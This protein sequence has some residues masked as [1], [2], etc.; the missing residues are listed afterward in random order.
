MCFSWL[1]C[2]TGHFVDLYWRTT[3]AQEERNGGKR[4]GGKKCEWRVGKERRGG[5]LSY[6][7]E[8][9]PI[10][11]VTPLCDTLAWRIP[12]TCRRT[13]LNRKRVAWYYVKPGKDATCFSSL[14]PVVAPTASLRCNDT[15]G[16]EVS[17]CS[18]WIPPNWIFYRGFM[19]DNNLFT[20]ACITTQD[21]DVVN[22]VSLLNFILT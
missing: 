21:E 10:V 17:Q 18:C 7:V 9:H 1:Y 20:S 5:Q 22:C 15:E 4:R 3:S 12:R 6:F 8:G 13:Q 14:R 2:A 19:V 11:L 16:D